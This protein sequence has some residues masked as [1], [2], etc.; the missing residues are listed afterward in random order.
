MKKE[1]FL[2]GKRYC[3]ETELDSKG[4]YI[5]IWAGYYIH[6]SN[7]KVEHFTIFSAKKYKFSIFNYIGSKRSL[8]ERVEISIQKAIK[9][10]YDYHYKKNELQIIDSNMEEIFNLDKKMNI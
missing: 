8:Q 7:I 10:V 5:F 9:K 4:N 6:E 3:I 1:I 2:D